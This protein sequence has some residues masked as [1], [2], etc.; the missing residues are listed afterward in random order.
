[1][2]EVQSQLEAQ[3]SEAIVK[4]ETISTLRKRIQELENAKQEMSEAFERERAVL[5]QELVTA[6][7]AP[8]ATAYQPVEA[9]QRSENIGKST[10]TSSLRQLEEELEEQ[11]R[12]GFSS[13]EAEYRYNR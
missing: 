7:Q 4:D 9:V 6:R 5:G 2:E 11:V 12:K 10:S 3:I 8:V 13:K 1:M